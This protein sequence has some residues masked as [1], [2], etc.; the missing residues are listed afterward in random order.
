M[1][2]RN[3]KCL[4]RLAFANS[5]ILPAQY[6]DGLIVRESR[7]YLITVLPPTLVVNVE[8]GRRH[9]YGNQTTL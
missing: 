2:L 1:W 8:I 5:G 9:S 3:A 7:V 4:I 6:M